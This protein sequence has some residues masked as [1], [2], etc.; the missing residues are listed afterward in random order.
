VVNPYQHNPPSKRVT[1]LKPSN[2]PINHKKPLTAITSSLVNVQI[3]KK[4]LSQFSDMKDVPGQLVFTF[5]CSR[6]SSV[7]EVSDTIG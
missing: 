2:R 7:L 6:F 4:R 1:D 3:Y 5:L